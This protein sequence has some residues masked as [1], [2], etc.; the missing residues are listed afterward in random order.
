MR[1]SLLVLPLL[2]ACTTGVIKLPDDGE[3]PA[4]TDTGTETDPPPEPEDT[5]D[6]SAAS[7][8]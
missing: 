1:L 5:G 4:D 7:T 3:G 6:A 8:E 2:T